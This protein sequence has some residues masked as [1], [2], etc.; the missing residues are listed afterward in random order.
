MYVYA[1]YNKKCEK[2]YV[3]QT[4]DIE[5]RLC[6]HNSSALNKGH[7]T[8]KFIGQWQLIYKEVVKDRSTA[9]AR[10]KQLKSYQ[11]RQFLKSKMDKIK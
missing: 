1:I 3:G 6:E 7:Y 9:I 4:N 11:G 10:E 8:S 5:R 2:V